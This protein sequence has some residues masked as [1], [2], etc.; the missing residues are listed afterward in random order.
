MKKTGMLLLAL[1][2]IAALTAFSLA[3]CGGP[4]YKVDYGSEKEFYTNARDSYPAG[5][6]VELYY[7]LIAM[8]MDCAFYLDGEPLPFVYEEGK[9]F[10]V[11]FTMP[12]HDV[13]LRCEWWNTMEPEFPE[14]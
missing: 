14:E 8:D 6:K 12:D 4:R 7:D 1:L 10:V 13:E 3:G 11:R 5:T 2:L 9:G